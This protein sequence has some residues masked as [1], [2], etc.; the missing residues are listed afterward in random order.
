MPSLSLPTH[1]LEVGG[2]QTIST[3]TNRKGHVVTQPAGPLKEE[4]HVS[5][6]RIS[7]PRRVDSVNPDSPAAGMCQMRPVN[8]RLELCPGTEP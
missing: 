1:H 4:G 7:S 8:L 3:T 2:L 6:E 5:H